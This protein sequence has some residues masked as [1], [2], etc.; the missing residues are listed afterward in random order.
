MLH[1]VGVGALGPVFRTYEPTRDRL[2][3]VKVFRLDITPEQAQSL[4]DELV[5][6][7]EAGLFHPS[8][9]E[10]IAAG[11]EGTSAYR[12]DEY[13]AAETL[14]VALRH[15]APAPIEKVLPF[16]TQ[17]GG[18]IDFARTAGIGHGALHPRDVFVTPEEARAGGF[19]VVEALERVGLRAPV[20][21]P[22]TAPERIAGGA[23]GAP[24]D[25]FSLA[26][27]AYE[28]MT[29]RRPSGTGTQ[30][31]PV[32]G[33]AYAAAVHAVIVR[34]MNE[35]PAR[36]YPSALAFASALDAA[37][38]GE[39]VEATAFTA[40][41]AVPEDVDA[42]VEDMPPPILS[43]R[44]E[45]A[46]AALE[47][48]EF[49]AS[50]LDFDDITVERD[51]QDEAPIAPIRDQ[52]PG[53]LTAAAATLDRTRFDD[54]G[55]E[56]LAIE[57]VERDDDMD[58]FADEF[59][60]AAPAADDEI[61]APAKT[62]A[63]R[64]VPARVLPVEEVEEVGED[65]DV[66]VPYA[67]APPLSGYGG[68]PVVREQRGFGFVSVAV[69]VVLALL[70]GFAAG[71]AVRGAPA[72]TA[73]DTTEPASSSPDAATS[74]KQAATPSAPAPKPY[75]EQAVAPA[76]SEPPPAVSEVPTAGAA[77]NPAPRP[78]APAPPKPAASATTGTVDVRSTP[79]GAGVTLDGRWRGRTP[80]TVA[81]LKFGTY[82]V[83]VVQPGF[84]T[85]RED[86]ALS[87][88]TPS[89]ALSFRLQRSAP[90]PPAT[91]PAAR[92]SAT[93]KPAAVESY[94][95][96]IYVDSRPRGARVLVDG[97]LMG[98]T[99]VRIPEIPVGSHVVRLQLEDHRDW[100]TSTRV[101]SSQE[102]RVT[103]SLERI[104]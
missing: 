61:P 2:V 34:A 15:Y 5:K 44:A 74:T 45:P 72:A 1:Q 29:G 85:A 35:D 23:W 22:Y 100:S 21:R 38:G 96:S 52:I 91:R 75:S 84:A 49:R 19:G 31:A 4:A 24:A 41:T 67:G 30:I 66:S 97:K 87:S 93:R 83:R 32:T 17:L 55:I 33:G 58:S 8:I 14:D 47:D 50:E 73:S 63:A 13:V 79:S 77:A 42:V 43:A 9:V 12:A 78:E 28:L 39:R 81:D 103:G 54:E 98:T 16:I 82:T 99:P 88:A 10:P 69:T 59:A 89:R 7:S 37:S 65:D 71:Y 101:T 56:D 53:D 25:V 60:I 27:I 48:A 51:L 26:V 62:S 36:R 64:H 95:G 6:P 3:A 11:V 92:D 94:V 86:V 20:R 76:P 104:R 68:D 46:Q 18:A 80:L 70:V 90:P 57:R 40:V 102:S